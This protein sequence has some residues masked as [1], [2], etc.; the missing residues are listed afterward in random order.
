MFLFY[1]TTPWSHD[2]RLCFVSKRILCIGHE[3][4]HNDIVI[5]IILDIDNETGSKDLT[6][7]SHSHCII[8]RLLHDL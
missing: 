2:A 6:A 5:D 3:H 4:L 7:V 8:T 1:A